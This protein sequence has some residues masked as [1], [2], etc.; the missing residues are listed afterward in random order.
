MLDNC[1]AEIVPQACPR[2]KPGFIPAAARPNARSR[3]T[4]QRSNGIRLKVERS[5][6]PRQSRD[7]DAP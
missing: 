6:P 4:G 3:S 1:Q 2:E 7:W 5:S